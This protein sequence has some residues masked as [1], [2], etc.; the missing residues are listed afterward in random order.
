MEFTPNLLKRSTKNGEK[1]FS[2]FAV[3]IRDEDDE[4]VARV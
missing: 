2:D 3:E 4:L 1:H